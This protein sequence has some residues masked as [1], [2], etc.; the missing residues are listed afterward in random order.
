MKTTGEIGQILG[1]RVS[2][3]MDDIR[4]DAV[5]DT[6]AWNRAPLFQVAAPL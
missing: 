2:A 4:L 5:F 6:K 3:G 1:V